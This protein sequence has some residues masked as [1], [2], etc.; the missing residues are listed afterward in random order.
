MVLPHGLTMAYFFLDTFVLTN[1]ALPAWVDRWVRPAGL[2]LFR[3]LLSKLVKKSIWASVAPGVKMWGVLNVE[4]VVMLLVVRLPSTCNSLHELLAIL[5]M[6]WLGFIARS[7]YFW[8]SAAPD[9]TA[10]VPACLHR[11][12]GR[13]VAP[14]AAVAA[15]SDWA[16]HA[17]AAGDVRSRV[18]GVLLP[19][20]QSGACYFVCG[21]GG[22]VRVVPPPRDRPWPPGVR[23]LVAAWRLLPPLHPRRR[24][25]RQWLRTR[26]FH[27][28]KRR[29]PAVCGTGGWGGWGPKYPKLRSKVGGQLPQVG[30]G[31]YE[32]LQP[33]AGDGGR[34]E[35]GLFC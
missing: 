34:W 6:D 13:R 31:L 14:G 27:L 11:P 30:E 15:G 16:R 19:H 1:L 32:P 21:A 29:H 7:V 35:K 17:A 33:P 9:P 28:T 2:L 10:Y 18:P 3:L 22:G 24:S 5:L 20:V 26:E 12:K 25:T 8:V 23:V 4:M